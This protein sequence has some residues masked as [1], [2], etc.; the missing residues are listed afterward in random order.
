MESALCNGKFLFWIEQNDIRVVMRANA[1]L[2]GP[3]CAARA[4]LRAARSG[5]V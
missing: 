5:P 4:W 2:Y 1:V 3:P